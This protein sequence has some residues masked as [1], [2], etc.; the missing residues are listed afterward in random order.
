MQC[1]YHYTRFAPG[2]KGECFEINKT[3]EGLKQIITLDGSREFLCEVQRESESE[4]QLPGEGGE[5]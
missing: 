4:G 2:Q 5:R 1:K 3:V